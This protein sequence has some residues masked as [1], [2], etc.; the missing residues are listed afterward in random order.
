MLST[1]KNVRLSVYDILTVPKSTS[2]IEEDAIK[3][4]IGAATAGRE[5]A[6]IAHADD[7]RAYSFRCRGRCLGP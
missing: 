4:S 5:A 6:H 1:T 3:L 7:K 2:V